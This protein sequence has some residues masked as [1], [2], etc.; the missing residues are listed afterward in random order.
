MIEEREEPGGKTQIKVDD[1]SGKNRL[2]IKDLAPSFGIKLQNKR[3]AH[4]EFIVVSDGNNPVNIK[5]SDLLQKSSV[6][7]NGVE[8]AKNIP[9]K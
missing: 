9:D 8:I 1:A 6:V 5:F 2:V 4:I 3:P 7:L